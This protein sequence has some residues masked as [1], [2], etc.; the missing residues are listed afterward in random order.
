MILLPTARRGRCASSRDWSS[1]RPWAAWPI[2][3]A[4]ALVLPQFYLPPA[5]RMTFGVAYL[6]AAAILV[7]AV[8][9]SRRV[10]A[11]TSPTPEPA[12]P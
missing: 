12:T 11:R 9:S 6:V 1:P 8:R 2:G 7:A 5:G 3:L 4:A 10:V